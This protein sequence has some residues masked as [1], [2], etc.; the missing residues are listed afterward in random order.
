MFRG[1]PR[2]VNLFIDGRWRTPEGE[3]YAD[4]TSPVDGQHIGYVAQGSRGDTTAAIRSAH[5]A[6][7]G[8]AATNVFERAAAL[9]RV[10]DVCRHRARELAVAL[11]HD[12]GKPLFTEAHAEVDEL[13]HY[14]TGAAEDVLRFNG[15]VAPS[16]LPGARALVER[17]PLGVVGVITPWNWP[18]TM[19]AQL[20][21]PALAVGNTVVWVPAPS[22]SL[23]SSVLMECL[24]EAELPAGVVNFVPG[25]GPVVGDEVAGHPGVAAVAFVGSTATGLQVAR[26]AAGKV[27]LMEMG[28]NGPLVVMDDA[29]LDRA[30][31]GTV[32]G[33]FL[34]SGQS[35]A[36]AER[37][38]VHRDLHR[39]FVTALTERVNSEVVLGDPFEERT[40]LGPLNNAAVAQKM[41]RH[42]DDALRRG[43][44]VTTGGRPDSDESLYWPPTVLDDVSRDSLVAR[45]ETFGPIAPV[46]PIE[47]LE[48]AIALT[49]ALPYG[50]MAAIYT[51]DVA[52]GLRYADAVKSAWVNVNESTN[53]WEPHLP[54]GGG[55]GTS[56][57]VG[58]V[59]GRYALDTLTQT[60]TV[61]LGGP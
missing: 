35:C 41:T 26:R 54:F 39:S 34:C 53:H 6:F 4:A 44:T 13:V 45:E 15:V 61:I 24:A 22:T 56:S 52:A 37:I 18:Y 57:G 11:T 19:P 42:V 47:S 21:A 14:F 29:D 36:A 49:N 31:T 28:N 40:T 30:V 9:H 5:Q 38:L 20:I 3:C 60:R 33:S 17:R 58:R 16:R 12:Q 32:L 48:D 25:P 27:Q 43:A 8:W 51:R 10:A 46:L 50:L 2:S 55:A 7:P 1:D 23:C 59:G